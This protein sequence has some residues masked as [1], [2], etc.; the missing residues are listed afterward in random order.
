MP[1]SA[2]PRTTATHPSTPSATASSARAPTDPGRVQGLVR[3]R[4]GHGQAAGEEEQTGGMGTDVGE[5]D[6]RGLG[7]HQPHR[8][9]R[10]LERGLVIAGV[11][12]VPA[13]RAVEERRPLGIDRRI[14]R[15]Q[16]LPR[17]GDGAL[18]LAH[19]GRHGGRP[20]DDA[21]GGR[22]AVGRRRR[23]PAPRVGARARS[24]REHRRRR[25]PPPP[26]RPPRPTPRGRVR[27]RRPRPNGRRPRRP[28]TDAVRPRSEPRR[29]RRAGVAP[30]WAAVAR[31]R[32]R[33]AAD[34]GTR[35]RR[36][37]G[38]DMHQDALVDRLVQPLD[39]V[40]LG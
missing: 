19:Q 36:R 33:A 31:R 8:L 40:A 32:P 20:V 10:V 38:L 4:L 35:S 11:P 34:D 5:Q 39:E 37:R 6:R 12:E 16:R 18:W 7:R 15:R 26:R 17:Q 3:L 9:E 14:D 23:A 27:R 25:R 21:P 1:S 29:T 2:C 13:Q 22:W 30:R 28:T 24:A